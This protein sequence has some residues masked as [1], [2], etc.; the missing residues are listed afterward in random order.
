[1][2]RARFTGGSHSPNCSGCP[3]CSD[4]AAALMTMSP[5]ELAAHLAASS[6]EQAAKLEASRST[7]AAFRVGGRPKQPPTP[8]EESMPSTKPQ[9][10]P[11]DRQAARRAIGVL[12]GEKSGSLL[13]QL[14]LGPLR[15]AAAEEV[16]DRA[17]LVV[18]CLCSR[19]LRDNFARTDLELLDTSTLKNLASIAMEEVD[20]LVQPAP[21]V[22]TTIRRRRPPTRSPRP[23][24]SS[25]PRAGSDDRVV[26]WTR[27]DNLFDD[28]ETTMHTVADLDRLH[29]AAKA[30]HDQIPDPGDEPRPNRRSELEEERHRFKAIT[31]DIWHCRSRLVDIES[32]SGPL[33]RILDGWRTAQGDLGRLRAA[34]EQR[35]EKA[36]AQGAGAKD[37]KPEENRVAELTQALDAIVQ[38]WNADAGLVGHPV[39]PPRMLAVAVGPDFDWAN[40]RPLPAVEA[41]LEELSARRAAVEERMKPYLFLQDEPTSADPDPSQQTGEDPR[42]GPVQQPVPD[43][44]D[45][46][47]PSQQ[48]VASA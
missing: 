25:G 2:T 21:S 18:Q 19:T 15:Q 14:A 8:E 45:V 27:P 9:S 28:K 22:A 23:R 36:R 44:G 5:T 10:R 16:E 4:A 47:Q 42:P 1:M 43:P 35:L 7:R 6:A 26:D 24:T 39:P 12:G 29:A 40:A 31:R 11:S 33:T 48:P 32:Q 46:E 38:G 13:A 3:A 20:E 30:R 34:A 41:A 37:L 17:A